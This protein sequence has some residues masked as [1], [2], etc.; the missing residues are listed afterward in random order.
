M[1]STAADSCHRGG[2]GDLSSALRTGQAPGWQV[3][4]NAVEARRFHVQQSHLPISYTHIRIAAQQQDIGIWA[5]RSVWSLWNLDSEPRHRQPLPHLPGTSTAREFPIR[6]L[7]VTAWHTRCLV[8]I[9][10]LPAN[11]PIY[12]ELIS[13]PYQVPIGLCACSYAPVPSAPIGHSLPLLILFL[14]RLRL[15]FPSYHLAGK[16]A[17]RLYRQTM[18]WLKK[19][20]LRGIVNPLG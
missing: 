8:P 1:P 7:F 15:F 16:R 4:R 14:L 20:S 9:A 10:R 2:L 18:C 11:L 5:A 3:Q 6:C 19:T 13:T 12:L 17:T